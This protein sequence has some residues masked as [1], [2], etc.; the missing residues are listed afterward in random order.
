MGRTSPYAALDHILSRAHYLIFEFDGPICD[1]SA[2]MPA[3]TATSSRATLKPT[4]PTRPPAPPATP[5]R[6]SP[7]LRPSARILR[8]ASTAS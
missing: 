3:T 2:A 1:L 5:S 7:A 4:P 6:S 8:H